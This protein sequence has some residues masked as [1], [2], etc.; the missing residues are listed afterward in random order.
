MATRFYFHAAASGVSGTLPSAEQ[1]TLT[2]AANADAQTVNR[3]MNTTIGSAATQLNISST[4]ST[5]TLYYT[6][7]VSPLIYQTSIAANTWV[8]AFAAVEANLSC[9][10]PVNGT[11]KA[12]NVN[13]YV[14]RPS[15]GAKVGTILDGA[16]AATVDEQ[17]SAGG[18]GVGHVVNCTGS[19]VAGLTSGD[20]VIIIEI[21]FASVAS[22]IAGNGQQFTF[23]GATTIT[24][25][26]TSSMDTAASYIETP[27]NLS[28]SAAGNAI[29]KSLTETVTVSET[30]TN[31]EAKIRSI[32]Q[33]ITIGE[34]PVRLAAKN[35]PL[36]TQ[37]IAVA[38]SS[39]VRI[40]GIV[41]ALATQTVGIAEASLTRLATKNRAISQTVTVGE[42]AT[43]LAVKLRALATQSVTVSETLNRIKALIRPVTQ[44]ITVSE[45]LTRR[46]TKTKAIPTQIITIGETAA[47]QAN[48]IRPLLTQSI[49]VSESL[50]R[51][52][53]VIRPLATQ[54]ITVSE[55]LTRQVI[56]TKALATQT[57]IVGESLIRLLIKQ[58]SPVT[59]SVTVS[60]LSLTRVATKTR[61]LA[62]QTVTVSDSLNRLKTAIRAL[63][64]QTVTISDAIARTVVHAGGNNITRALP[65]ETITV[66]ESIVRR[67]AKIRALATQVVVISDSLARL[68][69]KIRRPD[70]LLYDNFNAAT[71]NFT[72]GGASP[73]AQ[74]NNIYRSGGT[75]GTRFASSVNSNVMYQ[76]PSVATSAG[77]TFATLNETVSSWENFELTVR[78]KTVQQLRQTDPPNNWERAWILFRI[79]D[80]THAYYFVMKNSGCELGRSDLG[81]NQ[82]FLSTPGNTFGVGN[83][84]TV[85]IRCFSD[86]ANE[87]IKI[88]VW[89]D[90]TQVLS[91]SDDAAL[92]ATPPSATMFNPG[93]IGLYNED[94]EAEFDDLQVLSIPTVNVTESLARIRGKT[95]TLTTETVTISESLA[96]KTAKIRALATQ[97]V[98]VSE[99]VT[100]ISAK[101]RTLAVQ[102]IVVSDSIA[103]TVTHG[104]VNIT[105]A[106]ATETIAISESIIR[107]TAKIRTLAT[108][109]VVISESATRITG[110]V[111]ALATQTVTISES[112]ARTVTHGLNIVR[113]LPTETVTISESLVRKTA[114]IRAISVQSVTI[115]ET[116]AK[117]R[118]KIRALVTE[119]VT[120]S[121]S[122][123]RKA[124]KIRTVAEVAISIIEQEIKV[125][126]N[127]ILIVAIQRPDKGGYTKK[128]RQPKLKQ[129]LYPVYSPAEFQRVERRRRLRQYPPLIVIPAFKYNINQTVAPFV[130]TN[131]ARNEVIVK[132]ALAP[133]RKQEIITYTG[134]AIP[135]LIQPKQEQR[136]LNKAK[137]ASFVANQQALERYGRKL[138]KLSKL[139]KLWSIYFSSLHQS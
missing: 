75:T 128:L 86:K 124:Q 74:W 61:A 98:A 14:W 4:N 117:S 129:I 73:N 104:G 39:L 19:S 120:I 27:E 123:V 82:I 34:T 106:L 67:T 134:K 38:E 55:F 9:N 7:F 1:S 77:Q 10:F 11:N 3:S 131:P 21:W 115:S 20:A 23:D 29:T 87:A 80:P 79:V 91:I 56:K 132:F 137:C 103:R 72:E 44:S 94:A 51:I 22:T 66:S 93:F 116:L 68:A 122:I 102:T 127:G 83:W 70:D 40:K 2:A 119:T 37:T 24:E 121:D 32:S 125:F 130:I 6:K 69:A 85:R 76:I 62:T 46:A 97:T 59:Q 95:R 107:R 18:S 60:E 101:I 13:I 111:R 65:T 133:T 33:T 138:N 48:K 30:V 25:N 35:R 110:K 96:R 113:A 84:N 53:G 88:T 8:Y 50:I 41:K 135:I 78:I 118:G 64:T 16:T 36:P 45:S 90:G 15:T 92:T 57:I 31:V 126:K 47:R 81:I 71:Y 42:T 109:T 112:I 108:Q 105:R 49:T 28:L 54:T 52:K 58:R 43:R 99:S 89:V 26:G 136:L 139:M 114:K 5:R 17:A 100:R 63:A 12:V